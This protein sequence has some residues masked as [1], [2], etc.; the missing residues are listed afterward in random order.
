MCKKYLAEKKKFLKGTFEVP[1]TIVCQ[2]QNL[3]AGYPADKKQVPSTILSQGPDPPL[4]L[5]GDAVALVSRQA[6]H[7]ASIMYTDWT[8]SPKARVCQLEES[9]SECANGMSPASLFVPN[10]P[11]P[12]GPEMVYPPACWPRWP[13]GMY[14]S[15]TQTVEITVPLYRF[16]H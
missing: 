5:C 1:S 6:A 8:R 7:R 11:S 3:S 9:M 15:I 10:V 2:V 4:L 16:R 14:V 13:E 12:S